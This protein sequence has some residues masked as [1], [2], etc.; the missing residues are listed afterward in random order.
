M[1]K[2]AWTSSCPGEEEGAT[3]GGFLCPGRGLYSPAGLLGSFL[4]DPQGLAT[5]I[6]AGHRGPIHL[7]SSQMQWASSAV[8]QQANTDASEATVLPAAPSSPSDPVGMMFPGLC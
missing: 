2:A 4:A 5:R 8:P 7:Y 6:L 3:E 1:D